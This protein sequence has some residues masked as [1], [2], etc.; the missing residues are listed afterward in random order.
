MGFLW[1]NHREQESDLL[2][3]PQI[4]YSFQRANVT[5]FTHQKK[6]RIFYIFVV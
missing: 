5:F 2:Y 1:S 4:L 3:A 6:A